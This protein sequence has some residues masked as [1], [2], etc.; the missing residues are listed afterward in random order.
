MQ[1]RDPFPHPLRY[2][3][4]LQPDPSL[5]VLT[6]IAGLTPSFSDAGILGWMSRYT[7]RDLSDTLVVRGCEPPSGA[8]GCSSFVVLS[9]IYFKSLR[10][11]LEALAI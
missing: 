4:F 8:V 6:W 2:F 9:L 7:A 5:L 10:L 11:N 3:L 1:P